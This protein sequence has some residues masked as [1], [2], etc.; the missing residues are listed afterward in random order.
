MAF[1]TVTFAQ[2]K[3][4]KPEFIIYFISESEGVNYY[5][6]AKTD[7]KYNT[8]KNVYQIWRDGDNH[9]FYFERTEKGYILKEIKPLC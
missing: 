5:C 2:T 4:N 3:E 1:C 6:L 8:G 9:L 7:G